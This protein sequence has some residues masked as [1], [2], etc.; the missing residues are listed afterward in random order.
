MWIT[1]FSIAHWQTLTLMI[2]FLQN[3]LIGKCLPRCIWWAESETIFSSKHT[4]KILLLLSIP[5]SWTIDSMF[6]IAPYASFE[7]GT[8]FYFLAV[9]SGILEK[10]IQFCAVLRST[11]LILDGMKAFYCGIRYQ[12]ITLPFFC[13]QPSSNFF[14]VIWHDIPQWIK[15]WSYSCQVSHTMALPVT[16]IQN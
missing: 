9:A 7:S 12:M 11:I 1:S 2:H 10:L 8:N 4:D 5:N 13:F 14:F 16:Q 3:C 15:E 6:F